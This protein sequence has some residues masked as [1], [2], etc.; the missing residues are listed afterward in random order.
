MR[1]DIQMLNLWLIRRFLQ[2]ALL[3]GASLALLPIYLLGTNSGPG[4]FALWVAIQRW[5]LPVVFGLIAI[6]FAAWRWIPA[7]QRAVFPY[8]GGRWEGTLNFQGEQG[9]GSRAVR[10]EVRHTLFDLHVLMESDQ[11]TSQT[12]VVHAERSVFERYRLFYVFLNTRRE[13]ATNSGQAYRGLAILEV[14]AGKLTGHYF[15]ER[16]SQGELHVVRVSR[17]PWWHLLA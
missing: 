16:G 8:L 6:S 2:V 10:I 4:A 9:A 1:S 17:R 12:V 5:S 7:L 13:S 3:L 15:T 11:S 14:D